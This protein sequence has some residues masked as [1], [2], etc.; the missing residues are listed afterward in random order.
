MEYEAIEPFGDRRADWQAASIVAGL[1]NVI[2]AVNRG[3]KR[4]R[5][6]DFLLEFDR[7]EKEVAKEGAAPAGKTWQQMKFIAQMW[8]AAF[9]ADEEK[10][11]KRGR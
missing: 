6:K 1:A 11:K 7:Q 2:I 9:N 4:F 8:A 5:I 10:K 3:T